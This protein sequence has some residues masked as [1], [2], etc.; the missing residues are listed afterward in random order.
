MYHRVI[1][2]QADQRLL[3]KICP[4]AQNRGQSRKEHPRCDSLFTKK[5]NAPQVC[6]NQ[7]PTIWRKSPHLLLLCWLCCEA[8]NEEGMGQISKYCFNV[9]RLLRLEKVDELAHAGRLRAPVK[10]LNHS[11]PGTGKV[12]PYR[13]GNGKDAWTKL[14]V[15]LCCYWRCK[16]HTNQNFDPW[17]HSA[18]YLTKKILRSRLQSCRPCASSFLC[19]WSSRASTQQLFL[20]LVLSRRSNIQLCLLLHRKWATPVSHFENKNSLK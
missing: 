7:D 18:R 16:C 6:N 8:R 1:K 17:L 9:C 4:Q 2:G 19:A 11:R 13:V 20:K 15:I 10:V 5:C 14:L 12:Q 3:S